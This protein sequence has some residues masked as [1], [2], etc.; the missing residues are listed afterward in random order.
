MEG[1][2]EISI[3]TI[4]YT[5]GHTVLHTSCTNWTALEKEVTTPYT[6]THHSHSHSHPQLTTT[7]WR[8]QS[9][10]TASTTV[11]FPHPG[12]PERRMVW[13]FRF[14]P[15]WLQSGGG[16]ETL[17][18]P[19]GSTRSKAHS[20]PLTPHPL[21]TCTVSHSHCSPSYPPT[22]PFLASGRQQESSWL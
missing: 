11:I 14:N 9:R 20:S 6:P 4:S 16:G 8:P 18:G 19:Y 12:G 3:L 7:T 10:A 15:E 2:R 21:T 22:Y 17:A 1:W 13:Y 5:A